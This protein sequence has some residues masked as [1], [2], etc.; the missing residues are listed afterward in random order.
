MLYYCSHDFPAPVGR[1]WLLGGDAGLRLIS[2][3][4]PPEDGVEAV[5]PLLDET[6]RQL[7]QFFTGTRRAFDLPLAPMGTEFQRAVWSALAQIPYGSV[8]SY[9]DLAERVGRPKG[10]R[11][12]GQ[13]NSRNPLPFVLPCHRVIAA[14]G[15][16][17]GYSLGLGLKLW[18]LELE[19][20]R[21]TR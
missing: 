6:V 4:G 21:L 14:D 7:E 10:C 2:P 8:C 17:G 20:V 1:L 12:V 18:L 16:L 5:S 15:S 3:D 13:A 11:A 9:R 19:C